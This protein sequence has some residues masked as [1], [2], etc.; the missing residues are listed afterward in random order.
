M[1]HTSRRAL[2]GLCWLVVSTC[3]GSACVDTGVVG[4][5]CD[6]L[7]ELAPC[8]SGATPCAAAC[9]GDVDCSHLSARRV[10]DAELAL[11]VECNRSDDCGPDD[12]CRDHRCVPEDDD[13]DS[14]ETDAAD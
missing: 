13:D 4:S 12:M 9:T 3:I 11:C 2:N 14:D 10:C 1:A 7:C 8:A 6:P 5:S